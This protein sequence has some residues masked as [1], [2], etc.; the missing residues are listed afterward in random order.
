MFAK[1]FRF[2][3][4]NFG[5]WHKK[6]LGKAQNQRSLAEGK[7]KSGAEGVGLKLVKE[8]LPFSLHFLPRNFLMQTFYSCESFSQYGRNS[9]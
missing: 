2:A 5:K 1:V 8:F 3:Q 7:S 4:G 9:F 6:A